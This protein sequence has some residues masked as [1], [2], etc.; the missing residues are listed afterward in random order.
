MKMFIFSDEDIL[1]LEMKSFF[2][3]FTNDVIATSAFGVEVNSLKN[4]RNEFYL[5]GREITDFGGKKFLK[6]IFRNMMPRLAKVRYQKCACLKWQANRLVSKN[7]QK[8]QV[9]P[10]GKK[11]PL[12]FC[13]GDIKI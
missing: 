1:H 7:E 8:G 10:R 6:S 5:A 12:V 11:S 4:P 13:F 3:L 9:V 2:T